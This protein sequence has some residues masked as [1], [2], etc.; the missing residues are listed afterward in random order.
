[1]RNY[2]RKKSNFKDNDYN[3]S[4]MRKLL[5]FLI[6]LAFTFSLSPFISLAQTQSELWGMTLNN[7]SGFGTIFKTDGNGD[8]LQKMHAFSEAL[9]GNPRN[10]T[11]CETSGGKLYG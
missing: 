8:N 4:K 2:F 1:M 5:T 9:G 7:S 6:V 3:G 10:I 11:L